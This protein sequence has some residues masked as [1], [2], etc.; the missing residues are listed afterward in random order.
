MK[1]HVNFANEDITVLKG[2]LDLFREALEKN[3]KIVPVGR[4][5]NDNE[6]QSRIEHL[7]HVYQIYTDM[8]SGKNSVE[9][10]N[11]VICFDL[12]ENDVL[13]SCCS[14][15]YAISALKGEAK[16][17]M[18]P[19]SPEIVDKLLNTFEILGVNKNAMMFEYE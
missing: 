8:E 11:T 18:P 9:I 10:D 6:R 19:N 1:S 15:K 17:K 5:W 12:S 16:G 4:P 3:P 14:C 2:C 13:A 7:K